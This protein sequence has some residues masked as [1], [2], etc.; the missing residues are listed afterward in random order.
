MSKLRQIVDWLEDRG[1]WGLVITV[2]VIGVVTLSYTYEKRYEARTSGN[3][4]G[5][6]SQLE[7]F[8]ID[9]R[10]RLSFDPDAADEDIVVVTITETALDR[11]KQ[12]FGRWPWPRRVM[13]NVVDYL[14]QADSIMLDIGF[15]EPSG[16]EVQPDRAKAWR[17]RVRRAF[18]SADE[19][20]RKT[21]QYLRA[22][23]ED[24][25]TFAESGD[26]A[27]GK[28]LKKS[29]PAFTAAWFVEVSTETPPKDELRA[30]ESLLESY[31]YGLDGN[32]KIIPT[33]SFMTVPIDSVLDNSYGLSHI[34]FTP[35][36]DGPARR[37]YPFYGIR[38]FP[39]A[40]FNPDRPYLPIL[41]MAGAL[42]ATGFDPGESSFRIENNTLTIGNLEVPLDRKG[43]AL[44]RYNGGLRPR[45]SHFSSY[46][47]VP[48][49]TILGQIYRDGENASIEPDFFEGKKVLVGSTATGAH[50]LRT[51]PFSAQEAGVAIHANILDMFLNNEFL[52]PIQTR[53]TVLTVVL[54]TTAVG[55]LATFL[56][57]LMALVLTVL[58]TVLL[59]VMG[60]GLFNQG[61]L[62]NLSAPLL[63]SYVT[64]GL[65]TI[66]NLVFEQRKRRQIRNAFES[67]LTAS[68]MEEV[69]EEPDE[70]E[71]G[72]ERRQI[73]V[74]FSDIAGFTSFS[75]GKTATEVASVI[76][77]IMT[78]LTECVFRY[79]GVLDKYIGDE[80]VAEFGIVSAEPSNHARRACLAACD[81]RERITKLQE[82]WREQGDSVMEV[83]IGIHT[84]YAAT[85]NMGSQQLFDFTAIGD[86]VNLGS[87][88]EGA[89][90]HYDTR[91]M[92]SEDTYE[93][94]RDDVEV[95]ELDRLIVKGKDEPITV[96][97]LLGRKNRVDSE[98]LDLRDG[99]EEA[100]E[101][102]RRRDWQEA[103]NR[104]QELQKQFPED[105]PTT[106]FLDRAREFRENPPPDD[107]NGVYRLTKK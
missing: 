1:Y 81:M 76:N 8:F 18:E 27:L 86:N 49:E 3:T 37:F 80:L 44:I 45:D 60:F 99:F 106:I 89:N 88:L 73:T 75:E 57:P 70:L 54:W 12:Y 82:E 38:A 4:F 66:Y 55:L 58:L 90:K 56:S 87:R 19:S 25:G 98:T 6:Y 52:H 95:R 40:D 20:P 36:P 50:D 79:E 9:L 30:I 10:H 72:G 83:R 78:E 97:E 101:T 93:Q 69:L 7:F 14:S 48:V 2:L 21:K 102:Y 16:R 85:G 103:I 77:E 51:T 74:L 107:W 11:Y 17:Q 15:I 42:E 59:L 26:E 91:S 23:F 34:S 94:V 63:S 32:R 53:D 5:Y 46:T 28:S 61:Y 35:D 71:L 39:E 47:E 62:I 96:Y 24:L 64:Y 104:F 84:G 92:I 29:G 13:A 65:V 22:V 43:R 67:Y 31:G 100:L 68:V 41:G 33:S 105:G